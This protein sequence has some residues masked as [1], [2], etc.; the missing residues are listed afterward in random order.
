MPSKPYNILVVDD[1]VAVRLSLSA[2]LEDRD[3]EVISAASGEEALELLKENSNIYLCTIDMRLPGIDGNA[4]ILKT[5]EMFP[6][7]KFLIYTGSTNYVLPQNLKDIGICQ[8]DIFHKPL[9]DLFVISDAI[10][11]LIGK[12]KGNC[13]G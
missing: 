2:F 4:L 13:N 11:R 5:Y 10:E 8:K 3:F 7:M 12:N 6:E 9:R 1:E